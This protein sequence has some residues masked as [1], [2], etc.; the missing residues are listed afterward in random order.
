M[1]ELLNDLKHILVHMTEVLQVGDDTGALQS[2]IYTQ[3]EVCEKI[4][5]QFDL[6]TRLLTS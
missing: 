2:S 5:E 6:K 4:S 3:V 1:N